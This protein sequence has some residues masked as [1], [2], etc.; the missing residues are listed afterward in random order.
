MPNLVC[1][2]DENMIRC[3]VEEIVVEAQL[4]LRNL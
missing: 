4:K 1:I 3:R 2:Y